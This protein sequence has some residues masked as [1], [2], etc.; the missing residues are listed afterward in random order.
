MTGGHIEP[1]IPVC[2]TCGTRCGG[3][4]LSNGPCPRKQDRGCLLLKNPH[5][6]LVE[7]GP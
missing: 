7:A 6:Q 3:Y 5:Y 2:E 4:L 1:V